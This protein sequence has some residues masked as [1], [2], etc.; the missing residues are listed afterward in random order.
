[1]VDNN[2]HYYLYNNQTTG[3]RV[4]KLQFLNNGDYAIDYLNST[5]E[6]AQQEA[7]DRI[8]DDIPTGNVELSQSNTDT[9][10]GSSIGNSVCTYGWFG[11][12]TKEVFGYIAT[13]AVQKHDDVIIKLIDWDNEPDNYLY[14]FKNKK[15]FL[16]KLGLDKKNSGF[17]VIPFGQNNSEHWATMLIDLQTKYIYMFD[18]T[19][20]NF[21]SRK[22]KKEIFGKK[23][24]KKITLINNYEVQSDKAGTCGIWT[25]LMCTEMAKQNSI[26][27]ILKIDKETHQL[28]LNNEILATVAQ[29]GYDI[30]D[31]T[32]IRNRYNDIGNEPREYSSYFYKN[33]PLAK[34]LLREQISIEQYKLQDNPIIQQIRLNNFIIANCGSAKTINTPKTTKQKQTSK[35][36]QL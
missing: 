26:N 19:Q 28:T 14:Q 4:F 15:K 9:D 3:R 16:R 30:I 7:K 36:K 12:T 27:D 35:T 22:I 20:Q 25:M 29:Q 11:T 2:E 18:S 24:S 6:M 23:L 10:Q 34:Q 8:I 17:A 31:G 32:R 21:E 5:I 1:M 33:E 13:H